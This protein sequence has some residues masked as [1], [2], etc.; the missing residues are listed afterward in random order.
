MGLS[1]LP[2]L[3]FVLACPFLPES[4]RWLATR[5][6]VT[7]A[8]RAM[9]ALAKPTATREALDAAHEAL[10]DANSPGRPL[11]RVEPEED[12]DPTWAA[13]AC[14]RRGRYA[15]A[16]GVVQQATGTE[17][18]L[19]FSPTVLP[20]GSKFVAFLGNAGVG[21][22][23]FLGEVAAAAVSDSPRVGRRAMMVAGSAGVVV[24][25]GAFAAL[26]AAPGAHAAGLIASL[27][28]VM[29]AFSLGPGPFTTVYV[30]EVVP[31]RHRAKSSALATFLNRITS[32][33][34]AL[35][36]LPLSD[37]LGAAPVFLAYAAVA[38]AATALYAATLPDTLGVS[39]ETLHGAA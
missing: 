28:F 32:A 4:P 11:S 12:D 34:V 38:A 27:S 25:L 36:F 7:A 15:A 24:G 37:A 30:N 31:T 1:A 20:T 18:I 26:V 9:K 33:C 13:A 3:L 21:L 14:S 23:K 5:R 29:L 10:V 22:A 17:A 16:L 39:L 2:P 19:Y 6:K 35:S 8:R